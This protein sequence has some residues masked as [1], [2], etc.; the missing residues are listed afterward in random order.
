MLCVCAYPL[1]MNKTIFAFTFFAFILAIELMAQVPPYINYQAVLR[2]TQTGEELSNQDV[3]IVAKF[4]SGGSHG[5]IVYQEEHHEITTSKLGL[6]DLKLGGGYAV[7][8]SFQNVPWADG[9][10]WLGIEIDAGEGLKPLA[11][12]K[13][14][15]VPYALYAESGPE[16]EPNLDND[17]T[18]EIQDLTLSGNTLTI[19]DNPDAT[20]IDLGIYEN[21]PNLDNDPTNE[22][23][24]LNLAGNTLTIIDNPDATPIDLSAYENIPNLD[25]DP[26][27]EIQD[28]TFSGNTLTITDN[29]DAT[30]I[31]LSAYENIPNLDNDPTN[32]IQ[33]LTFSGNTLTITENPDATPIDLSAYENIPNLDND[34]T[35]EIQDLTL[36]GNTLTITDNPDATLIDLSAYENI[37][38]LDNDPTNE[39]Q[40]LTL[41]GNT[42]TITDNPDA[43]PIDLGIYENIPNLDNDPTNEIQ[44]LTLSGNTL[45][46]TDNPDATPI[47]LSAY[48]NIP[49]LDNDP[50]NEIQDLTLSGNTLTITDNPDAT[51]IDLS[52]YEN[53]PLP[54][55]HMFIGN[56]SGVATAVV[57]T[58]DV[59]LTDAGETFV[60]R[61]RNIPI[62]T[63][64]PTDGQKLTY[65][66]GTNEWEPVS[67]IV[68]SAVTKYYSVDPM[69]FVELTNPG[70]SIKM[71]KHNGLKFYDE[72]A[73]FAMLRDT[74]IRKIGAPVHLPH[75]ATITEIKFFLKDSGPG[76]MTFELQR[77][78]L[79]NYSNGNSSIAS[80]SSNMTS[81]K[82]SITIEVISN[83][84]VN[85]EMFTYRIFVRFTRTEG[86]D[87]QSNPENIQQVFYGAVIAY[88]E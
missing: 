23:Q 12:T 82:G 17:P 64:P 16:I 83:N 21:I 73:P 65:N 87:D 5:N 31:D 61:L 47:D 51:P 62:S 75:G 25:N 86:D 59:N 32:E 72:N 46:I 18:N 43:T 44:D 41:S 39:I 1:I 63:T 60:G 42:L 40:D 20:P 45:T 57:I 66:E 68:A 79:T 9:D 7:Q 81:G 53:Q 88:T 26:T 8:G 70:G 67:D 80:G 49:N 58:G 37:P 29:P 30:P 74:D 84:V 2:N 78:Q 14:A 54:K 4:L 48:E 56:D 24:D 13:F 22:I 6:I 35:N 38:N 36:S 19:T 50:T 10:I 33:D 34:P 52:I 85:N 28:L 69:D 15:S 27:N 11:T 76:S 77:K 55:G 3:F 71:Y